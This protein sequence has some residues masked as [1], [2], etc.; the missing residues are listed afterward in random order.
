M[1]A[2]LLLL[3]L[4]HQATLGSLRLSGK[5]RELWGS[6]KGLLVSQSLTW[7]QPQSQSLSSQEREE[8]HSKEERHERFG[9]R[10][11]QLVFIREWLGPVTSVPLATTFWFQSL[12]SRESSYLAERV[13]S[14]CVWQMDRLKEHRICVY[15]GGNTDCRKEEAFCV[16]G[17]RLGRLQFF[18]GDE[19]QKRKQTGNPECAADDGPPVAPEQLLGDRSSLDSSV[20]NSLK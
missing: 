7:P 13:L 3:N 11:P 19:V 5:R 2:L 20:C 8:Q 4:N 16:C 1:P 6:M 17:N 18:K 15:Y 10:T 14:H 12:Y 9:Y